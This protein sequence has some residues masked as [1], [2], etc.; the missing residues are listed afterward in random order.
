MD[1]L[2]KGW[3]SEVQ[4]DLWPGQAMSLEI[5]SKVHE[6]QS[7]YQHVEVFETATYGKLLTIDGNIQV[8]LWLLLSPLLSLR[9][10]SM[11]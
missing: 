8:W 6:E 2:P 9:P 1:S 5:K 4:K 11:C 10:L 3:F 7:Q